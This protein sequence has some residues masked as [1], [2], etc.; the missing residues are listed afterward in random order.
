VRD[1]ET[2]ESDFP[3][4]LEIVETWFTSY[5]GPGRLKS[6]GFGDAHE[7]HCILHAA[8]QAYEDSPVSI[9]Q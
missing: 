3:G 1:I 2:L 5:K 4:V 6:K 7:A 8:I 9:A